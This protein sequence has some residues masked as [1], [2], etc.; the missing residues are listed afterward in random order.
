MR[1]IPRRA[2]PRAYPCL[3]APFPW[4][5]LVGAR[6]SSERD[7]THPGPVRLELTRRPAQRTVIHL[8]VGRVTTN[9]PSG[10]FA[11]SLLHLPT[12]PDGARPIGISGPAAITGW[13]ARAGEN[14]LWFTG[15][16]CGRVV[17]GSWG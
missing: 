9:P 3:P 15:V 14:L 12:A 13:H 5:G 7:G 16:W 2:T 6:A 11:R 4:G 10:P 1:S 17:L 8:P